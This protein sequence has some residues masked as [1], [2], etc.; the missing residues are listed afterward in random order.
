MP[1]LMERFNLSPY[2]DLVITALDVERPKPDPESM[3]RILRMLN[4]RPDETLYVGDST[5]DRQTAESSGVTFL[6][7]KNPAISTGI[8]IDDHR[9]II[10]VIDGALSLL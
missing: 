9:K 3:T 5:I 1:H 4:V 6:A 7:Y 2:F 10:S 8:A